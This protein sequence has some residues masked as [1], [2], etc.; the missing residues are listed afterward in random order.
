M[1]SKPFFRGLR[2]YRRQ[3]KLKTLTSVLRQND[4]YEQI[5]I[6]ASNGPFC[7]GIENNKGNIFESELREKTSECIMVRF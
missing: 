4:Q 6:M 7:K 3:T 2:N 5:E 1:L